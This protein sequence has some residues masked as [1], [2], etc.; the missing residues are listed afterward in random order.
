MN[1][2]EMMELSDKT[3]ELQEQIENIQDDIASMTKAVEKEYE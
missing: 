2:P 3:T 1:S